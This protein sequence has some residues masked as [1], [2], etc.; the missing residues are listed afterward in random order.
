MS[1]AMKICCRTICGFAVALAACALVVPALAQDEEPKAEKPE[2]PKKPEKKPEKKPVVGK[3]DKNKKGGDKAEEAEEAKPDTPAAAAILATHPTTPSECVR[4]AKTLTDLGRPDLAKPLLKKVL[5][6]KLEPPQWEALGREFGTPVFL[7]MSGRA[8]LLPEA[9]DVAKAVSDAVAAKLVDVKRIE[10]L[11]AQLQ[12]ADAAKRTEA[13][14]A[15]QEARR[16]AIVPLISVL[17]DPARAEEHANVRTVLAGMGRPARG[18]LVAALDSADPKLQVEAMLTLTEM[19]DSKAAIDLATLC[20]AEKG[21]AAVREAAA[22]ALKQLLGRVP[23]QAEAVGWLVKSAKANFERRQP[24]EGLIDGRV[25]LWHWDAGKRQCVAGS[26]TPED[27]ARDLS[28]RFARAACALAPNDPEVRLLHFA[29]SLDAASYAAGLDTPLDEKDPAV[30]EAK[31]LGVK[32]VEDVLA[33]A[34]ANGHAA[35]ATA[36]ARLLGEIGKAEELLYRGDRP[37]PLVLALQNPD[38]RLRMAALK[39]ILALKP[40][41]AYAGSSYVPSA[42]G[43]FVATRGGRRALVG[44][45]NLE[46]A[47]TLAGMLASAGFESDTVTNGRELL[48]MAVGSPD[49]ELVMIDPGIMHPEIAT[50]LQELRR[51]PRTSL[52]RIGLAAR[53][54]FANLADR[55]AL[56]DPMTK[57]FARPH[58]EPSVRW[59]VEQ[60]ATLAPR[61]FVDLKTRQQQATDALDM[62]AELSRSA[63]KLY[64]L[65][66]VQD[67]VLVALYNPK[68]SVKALAILA[69]MN[70]VESQR[71]LVDVASRVTLPLEMRKAAATAFRENTQKYGI[72]LTTD[73]IRRQ[74]DRYNASKTLDAPTQHVLALILDCLEAPSGVKK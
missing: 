18:A 50:L 62:L 14:T 10:G 28:A 45:P 13:L 57:V 32:A 26:G 12:D 2:K 59:Q 61:E 55:S 47:R 4:A 16:A 40:T 19:N 41:K 27:A 31:K 25:E 51:D 74:Y 30:A 54:G 6:T 1:I 48:Q 17:A 39:A 11:I 72:L 66:P 9:K 73:E 38:R 70:S 56:N 24:I 67:A 58:D 37:A 34:M 36:A 35:A 22:K 49:Y 15:L 65:R 68:L 52:L 63:G 43:Y 29:A 20:L 3:A 5:D 53:E 46:Q 64:D 21:D 69:N 44:G 33:Y 7:D 23:T 8:E 42:L 60:L 71:T